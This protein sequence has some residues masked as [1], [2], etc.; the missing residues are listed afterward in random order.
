MAEYTDQRFEHSDATDKRMHDCTFTDC[1]FVQCKF[2]HTELYACKFVDCT[3]EKCTFDDPSFLYTSMQNCVF[4]ECAL[5]GISWNDLTNDSK[6]FCSNPVSKLTNCS[7]RYNTFVRVK[8][9]N[10]DFSTCS[11]KRCVFDQ[12]DLSGADFSTCKMGES[13]F[14]GCNLQKSDFRDAT[15]WLLDIRRNQVKHA[16]FSI[17]DAALLLTAYDLDLS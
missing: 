17:A 2:V 16:K 5:S 12:C 15:G 8:W 13:E 7:L 3:F 6:L 11:F 14:E 9:R 1:T 4:D 10:F